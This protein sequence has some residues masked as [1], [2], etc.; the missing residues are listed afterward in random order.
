M[1]AKSDMQ[2]IG[3]ALSQRAPGGGTCHACVPMAARPF[4]SKPMV[5]LVSDLK[6][7]RATAAP[8]GVEEADQRTDIEVPRSTR[9]FADGVRSVSVGAVTPKDEAVVGTF[10]VTTTPGTDPIL[11]VVAVTRDKSA[12]HEA[13]I[14]A[15]VA[16]PATPQP[17]S[18][19]VP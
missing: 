19:G 9:A 3:F 1:P 14:A 2:S 7:H 5:S 18:S 10:G 8:A 13:D 15:R 17:V 4:A 11:V 16:G 6:S 12:V